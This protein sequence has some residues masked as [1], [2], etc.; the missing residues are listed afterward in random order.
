MIKLYHYIHCPFCIRVRMA[1]G[2]LETKWESRPT[3]YHDEKTPLDLTGVKMLP[4]VQFE[5]GSAMNESLDII[6]KIDHK[7]ALKNKLLENPELKKEVEDL[8]DE[9]AGPVHNLC[10]P[11]WV[12]TKEFNQESREYFQSKKEKKRGPFHLL[13][14]RRNEFFSELP[15]LFEKLQSR[16]EPFYRD[17][18]MTILDIMVASHL[19]GLYVHPDFQFP[20]KIHEYLKRVQEQCQFDYHEDLWKTP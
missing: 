11:Y 5:D 9:F 13:V 20:I 2:F 3:H 7:D 14:Q 12:W 19:W 1:F 4:I 10:M 18:E 15:P 8:L 16:L 6:K 17:K